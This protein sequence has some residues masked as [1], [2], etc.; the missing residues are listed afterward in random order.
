[1]KTKLL[2]LLCLG[3]APCVF[4]EEAAGASHGGLSSMLMFGAIFVMMYFL[5]IRP[6]SKRAKEHRNLLANLSKGDEVVTQ[7]G[8]VGRIDRIADSFFILKLS[9]NVSV[10]VQRQ[11]VV[12]VLPKGTLQSI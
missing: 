8:I 7:G 4:A 2:A 11:S 6:Q 10:P 12:Q 9:D 3:F 5:M 1:M